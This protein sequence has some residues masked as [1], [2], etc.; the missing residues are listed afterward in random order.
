M[1]AS[2]LSLAA[3]TDAGVTY[4]SDY[5]QVGGT[6][7]ITGS[8]GVDSLTGNA[9]NADVISGGAGADT[10]VYG[11]G[12]DTF[13]GGAGNDTFDIDALGTSA[14]HVTIADLTAGDVIDIAGIDTGTATWNATAVTLGASATL[15][16]YLD[17]ASAGDG[18]TNS[19]ARYFQF[20]GDTYIVN[21]NTAGATFAATD[22][23]IEITG[24]VDLSDSTLAGTDLTIA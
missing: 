10:I 8:N 16:N 15:A 5:A 17:A 6:A 24:L 2:G 19:I 14:V 18:S 12:S 20:D 11:G 23:I 22:A 3:V 1:D 7:T 13:T 9:A 21:D 4:V